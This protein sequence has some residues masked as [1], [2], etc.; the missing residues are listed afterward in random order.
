[1]LLC[2][3]SAVVHV[4]IPHS[5][6]YWVNT[7]IFQPHKISQLPPTEHLLCF[8]QFLIS[9]CQQP[10]K[11]LHSVVRKVRLQE[12]QP[13][14][15][16]QLLSPGTASEPR[17]ARFS[18]RYKQELLPPRT[19]SGN[20]YQ[21]PIRGPYR[22]GGIWAEG[23]DSYERNASQTEGRASIKALLGV[24]TL[25]VHR[26]DYIQHSTAE[27]MGTT[28]RPIWVQIPALSLPTSVAVWSLL[29]TSKSQL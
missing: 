5:P 11:I 7:V 14:K 13:P 20:G 4:F 29:N 26:A 1:M 18:W 16:H 17:S 6:S 22:W 8:S 9:S 12:A 25:C 27:S 21:N 10:K 24:H 2:N 15:G 3:Y 28:P 19:H 23:W